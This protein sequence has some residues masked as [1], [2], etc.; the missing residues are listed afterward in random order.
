MTT[1]NRPIC[2]IGGTSSEGHYARDSERQ[3]AVSNLAGGDG[4]VSDYFRSKKWSPQ[5]P[6][7][8]ARRKRPRQQSRN[9]RLSD[10]DWPEGDCGE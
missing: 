1:V 7:R 6:E 4:G 2:K 8:R 10:R 5:S 9:S 3:T